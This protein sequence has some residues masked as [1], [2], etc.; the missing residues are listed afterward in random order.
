M[1]FQILVPKKSVLLSGTHLMPCWR[2]LLQHKSSEA[3]FPSLK[4][5][6]S[7]RQRSPM[8][9]MTLARVASIDGLFSLAEIGAE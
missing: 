3:H 6:A 1:R 7:M 8:P 9:A 2:A 5:L 4:L